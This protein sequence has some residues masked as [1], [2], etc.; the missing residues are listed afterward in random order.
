MTQLSRDLGQSRTGYGHQTW[1][2]KTD[3]KTSE[4]RPCLWMQAGVVKKKTCS[5]F[6]DCNTCTYDEAMQA[7]AAQG[8]QPSWQ[9]AMRLK[10][11][12]HRTC[13]HSLTQRIENRTCQY[14]YNCSSCD[15][16][17]YFEDILTPKTKSGAYVVRNIKGFDV[18]AGYYFHNGHTWARIENGGTIKIGFDD[19]MLKVLGKADALDLPLM[20]KEL[21]AGKAGWGLKRKDN[22]ADIL[23]P[24][25][26]VILEVNQKV[27]ENPALANGSPYSDGWLFSVHTRDIKDAF[28]P[29][30][31]DNESPAWIDSEV[32]VLENMIEEVAGPLATDGG[33]IQ[34]DVFGNLP[35][36]GW[37]N[38][39]KT[40]LK[41]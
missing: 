26:G 10:D 23:S 40:F 27:R 6:F 20:G 34:S 28:K 35:S 33:F 19:F 32:G 16:D 18:P 1:H 11:G 17:Q 22:L 39:T 14:N 13:R 7:K 24:V 25:N 38:L 9:D 4:G 31:D 37:Q 2:I 3:K 8:K 5:N 21:N 29:L 30:I 41:S 36:L 15:F 12:I